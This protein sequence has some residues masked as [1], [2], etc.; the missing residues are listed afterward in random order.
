[1][2]YLTGTTPKLIA[3]K[4]SNDIYH[5]LE[6]TYIL[7]YSKA[8]GEKNKFDPIRERRE[9][10]RKPVSQRNDQAP[11]GLGISVVKI[12]SDPAS[13]SSFSCSIYFLTT[14]SVGPTQVFCWWRKK[15]EAQCHRF[16]RSS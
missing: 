4:A 11:R 16:W 1:M 2:T 5:R 14:N 9:S 7:S 8:L 10:Q 12:A 6:N 13:S 3:N 15:G